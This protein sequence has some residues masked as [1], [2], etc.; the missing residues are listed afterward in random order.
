MNVLPAEILKQ[1]VDCCELCCIY[2]VP[3]LHPYRTVTL[4]DFKQAAVDGCSQF[5]QHAYSCLGTRSVTTKLAFECFNETRFLPVL[6]LLQSWFHFKQKKVL[7]CYNHV[8]EEGNL[9]IFEWMTDHFHMTPTNG[10]YPLRLAVKTG[11]L[12][13]VEWIMTKFKYRRSEIKAPRLYRK[14]AKYGHVHIL[15]W[16][17]PMHLSPEEFEATF[18]RACRESH[19]AALD[20]LHLR[21][22]NHQI[23][24]HFVLYALCKTGQTEVV[25][26]LL[27]TQTFNEGQMHGTVFNPLQTAVQYGHLDIVKLLHQKF[28]LG[29]VGMYNHLF[30]LATQSCNLDLARYIYEHCKEHIGDPLLAF[31]CLT[32]RSDSLP[33]LTWMEDT[34]HFTSEQ[35]RSRNQLAY[36]NANNNENTH[37]ARWLT[38]TYDLQE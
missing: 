4:T 28:G 18:Y 36:M 37:I 7:Q 26:W 22:Q 34:F 35:V 24:F 2:E 32:T 8:A 23:D 20:Y 31:Q 16:L 30:F 3:E 38:A 17:E 6:K 13:L 9:E 27:K 21:H 29:H 19:V 15:E 5:L 1:I 33:V 10:L 11:N 12:P 25:K 14:A